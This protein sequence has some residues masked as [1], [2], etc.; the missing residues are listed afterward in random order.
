MGHQLTAAAFIANEAFAASKNNAEGVKQTAIAAAMLLSMPT[1]LTNIR[2]A[3]KNFSPGPGLG[4]HQRWPCQRN[5]V[6]QRRKRCIVKVNS[7]VYKNQAAGTLGPFALRGG[8][9]WIETASRQSGK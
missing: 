4:R 1:Q 2:A 8:S 6:S 9:Y 5:A 7:V 3:E